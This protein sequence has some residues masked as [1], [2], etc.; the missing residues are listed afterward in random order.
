MK[1]LNFLASAAL[2]ASLVGAAS[3]S[4]ALPL[5]G[6]VQIDINGTSPGVV[7]TLPN[8]PALP[9]LSAQDLNTL[10]S[11][12]FDTSIQLNAVVD[13]NLQVAPINKPRRQVPEPNGLILLSLGIA[14]M[15]AL[16]LRMRQQAA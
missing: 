14:S 10:V 12:A 4:Q 13:L 2:F 6:T 5:L 15:G 7:V 3:S 16:R 1:N 8:P 9:P 11:N